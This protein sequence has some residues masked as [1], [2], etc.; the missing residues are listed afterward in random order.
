[1]KDH[2]PFDVPAYAS[3]VY[4]GDSAFEHFPWACGELPQA[5]PSG[6]SPIM[7]IPQESRN[8]PDLFMIIGRTENLNSGK[9]S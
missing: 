6:I 1:M 2:I 3:R 5:L 4:P 7:Y 9:I 8:F